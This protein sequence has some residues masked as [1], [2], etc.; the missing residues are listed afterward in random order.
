MSEQKLLDL[1]EKLE[2][3]FNKRPNI[4]NMNTTNI[5]SNFQNFNNI[6]RKFFEEFK[7]PNDTINN[8]RF[9]STIINNNIDENYIREI[10]KEELPRLIYQYQKDLS[11][12]M[13][14]LES[15]IDNINRKINDN[16]QINTNNI[17]NR[18]SIDQGNKISELEYKLSEIESFFKLWKGIIKDSDDNIYN[19]RMKMNNDQEL[20]LKQLDNKVSN[21]LKQFNDIINKEI[22]EIKNSVKQIKYNNGI[23]I[24]KLEEEMKKI[25]VDFNYLGKDLDNIKT[26]MSDLYNIKQNNNNFIK[27]FN[28]LKEDFGK[29]KEN[30]I[31]I[32]KVIK[33]RISQIKESDIFYVEQMNNNNNY[34]NNNE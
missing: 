18:N 25:K 30:L 2:E 6:N 22:S 8:S 4:P 9:N 21:E 5:N 20:K 17:E 33:P 10:I 3:K 7:N 24:N 12:R 19:S 23:E 34:N 28:L 32:N 27:D 26:F 14:Y 13:S 16:F 11:N 31:E 29:T 1:I 15:K